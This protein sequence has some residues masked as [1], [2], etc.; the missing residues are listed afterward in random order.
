M[1]IVI[2]EKLSQNRS[3]FEREI[4]DANNK[5]VSLLNLHT[6]CV[7]TDDGNKYVLYK[8]NLKINRPV[9]KYVNTHLNS[10]NSK[11]AAVKSLRLFFLYLEL[12]N[13][14]IEDFILD[15]DVRNLVSFLKG[16]SLK[17][18][19][20]L[21]LIKQRSNGTVNNYMAYI[22]DFI[23][24]C[25]IK[26]SALLETKV[27]M[28][29][30]E[31]GSLKRV[32]ISKSKLKDSL[33]NEVPAYISATEYKSILELIRR[34]YTIREELFV[35]LMYQLGLRIG[36]VL[37][38][39]FDDVGYVTR[40]GER[41]GILLLRNRFTDSE[42]QYCK[43]LMSIK[44][45][46]DYKD[47]QYSQLN[48][49]YTEMPLHNKLIEK[50]DNYIETAHLDAIRKNKKKYYEKN[51]ADIVNPRLGNTNKTNHYIF[52]GKNGAPIS[53]SK[54]NNILREIYMKV[55]I[56]IDFGNR[57]NNVSHRLR[58][59]FAMYHY[60]KKNISPPLLKKYMRH[61]NIN[62]V[63]CYFRLT[64]SDL[65]GLK[66]SYEDFLFEEFDISLE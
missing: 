3:Y 26:D 64:S 24:Y 56:E 38:L 63:F 40:S 42:H 62:S 17:G 53:Y 20:K 54:W 58:H 52:I 19:H 18:T 50:I 11:I 45:R 36:E 28:I 27:V 12:W 48:F 25:K 43:N 32:Q 39:T 31:V 8:L 29:L 23:K 35:R 60:I 37:G 59:G 61:R 16:N 22:I 9:Y 15:D 6:T 7:K 46:S 21:N 13:L 34:E 1:A 47:R 33:P 41:L 5:I 55:G 44:K 49:G 30:N 66:E 4:S 10:N 57:K 51:N 2:T 65:A 14:K